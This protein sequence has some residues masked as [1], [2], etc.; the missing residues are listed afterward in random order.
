[1]KI[2]I[3]L[4][5]L[6]LVLSILGTVWVI[7]NNSDTIQRHFVDNLKTSLTEQL[8]LLSREVDLAMIEGQAVATGLSKNEVIISYFSNNATSKEVLKVFSTSNTGNTF[9]AYYLLDPQGQAVVSTDPDFVGHNF[10]FRRYYSDAKEGASV[11]E[12]ALGTISKRMGY[13]FSKAVMD[14][15]GRLLG[16]VVAKMEPLSINRLIQAAHLNK[17]GKLMLTNENGVILYADKPE[18]IYMSL[19]PLSNIVLETEQKTRFLGV[20]INSVGYEEA[21]DIIKNYS[22]QETV[23]FFCE[24]DQEYE[25]AS[26]TRIGNRKFFLVLETE[27]DSVKENISGSIYSLNL[28]QAI[29][30]IFSAISVIFS[31]LLLRSVEK[32]R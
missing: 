27:L 23:E 4:L 22:T 8:G 21:A 9:S 12:A 7:G 30:V 20:N 15:D 10:S 17:Y 19:A 28:R 14:K 16:V 5:S 24:D 18:R 25:I 2:K 13:Y 32:S 29:L 26:V 6:G 11:L 1:M 31:V 3:K